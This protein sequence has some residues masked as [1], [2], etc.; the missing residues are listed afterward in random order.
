MASGKRHAEATHRV[1]LA[2]LLAVAVALLQPPAQW[3]VLGLII[4]HYATP[5]VR[6]Q[7]KKRNHPEHLVDRHFGWLAGKLWTWYWEPLASVIPHRHWA[8]HLPGPA[9]LIAALWL[10]GPWL[11]LIRLYAPEWY[12][13]A[14]TAC[15]W[16]LPGWFAQ[17]VVHLALDGWRVRW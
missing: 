2:T 14:W 16:T 15:V 11:V 12:D 9:T 7:Q 13:V 1:L 17:D 4:G 3:I 8:S 10:Y 5:D 6:D